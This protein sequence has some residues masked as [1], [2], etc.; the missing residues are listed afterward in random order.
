L[1]K[2][3]DAAWVAKKL[4]AARVRFA[5]TLLEEVAT[6]VGSLAIAE[7]EAELV[8]L[9]LQRF[10]IYREALNRRARSMRT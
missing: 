5:D 6:S 10:H 8:D 3:V 7:L 9:Q 1:G 2:S 4:N